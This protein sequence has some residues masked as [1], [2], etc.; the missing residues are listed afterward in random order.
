M[1]FLILFFVSL[2]I[3]IRSLYKKNKRSIVISSFV[4]QILCVI[5]P[6]L[7]AVGNF[8]SDPTATQNGIVSIFFILGVLMFFVNI[9]VCLSE[10]FKNGKNTK[11]IFIIVLIFE[12]SFIALLLHLGVIAELSN[13][14]DNSKVY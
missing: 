9:W 3:F 4:N 14:F 11:I 5:M 1:P 7:I 6:I 8:D 13:I 2:F 10:I 12:V